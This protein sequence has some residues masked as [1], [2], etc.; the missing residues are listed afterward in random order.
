[1]VTTSITGHLP[2]IIVTS[3]NKGTLGQEF[4]PIPLEETHQQK[5]PHRKQGEAEVP[6][7]YG[8]GFHNYGLYYIN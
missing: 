5:Q 6:R 2:T 1:M 8:V 3:K 4:P 7:F